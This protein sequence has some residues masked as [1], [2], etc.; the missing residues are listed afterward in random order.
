MAETKVQ[1]K[2]KKLGLSRP[3]KLELKKTVKTGQVRQSFSHGRSKMV[4]VEVRKKRTF[5]P[6]AGGH[7]TEVTGELEQQVKEQT[8]EVFKTP[9]SETVEQAVAPSGGPSLTVE[10]KAARARAL[11]DAKKTEGAA[12]PEPAPSETD[13]APEDEKA[14]RAEKEKARL[15]D[16]KEEHRREEQAK[17]AAAVAAAKLEALE[18][19]DEGESKGRAKRGPSREGRRPPQIRRTEHR[20]RSG[21]LTIAEALGDNEERTRS[22]ASIKRAREKEKQQQQQLLSEG[23]KVIRE[24]VIPEFITVQELSNRMAERAA[25]VIK[26]LMKMDVMATI[27]QT[28]DADTAELL[29]AEFGHQLKRVSEADVELGLKG[30]ADKD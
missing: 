29:V 20:R 28:I 25:D 11:E 19:D 9:I 5:A 4:T 21:K 10:E 3:G 18:G 17:A 15:A 22:L 30:E 6:D 7:M 16:E 1:N 26:A 8:L 24:V 13:D 14:K 12:L 23:Q 27:N 2:G